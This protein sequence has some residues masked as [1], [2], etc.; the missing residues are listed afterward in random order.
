MSTPMHS[1]RTVTVSDNSKV[2]ARY[3]TQSQH[4]TITAQSQ[5]SLSDVEAN[6]RNGA[7]APGRPWSGGAGAAR[8]GCPGGAT[9]PADLVLSRG[10][11]LGTCGTARCDRGAG[12]FGAAGAGAAPLFLRALR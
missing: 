10:R 8:V 3:T 5:H 1:H 7:G 11:G 4:M 12:T 2:T 9:G 6:V